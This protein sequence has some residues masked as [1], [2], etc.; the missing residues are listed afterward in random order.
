[1]IGV[2]IKG[3]YTSCG[4]WLFQAPQRLIVN[5]RQLHRMSS[6]QEVNAHT[7]MRLVMVGGC[8]RWPILDRAY[9]LREFVDGVADID[10]CSSTTW[11]EVMI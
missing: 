7:M 3:F 5:D 4:I 2:L 1:M 11:R 9:S 8:L 6:W 10:F